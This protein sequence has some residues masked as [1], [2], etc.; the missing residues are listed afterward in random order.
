MQSGSPGGPLQG[1]RVLD[2]SRVLSGPFCTM[3]LADLGA[4]VIK[5]EEPGSGDQ[6]R[7]IPPYVNGE[8]HYYLAINR[9]KQSVVIDLKK[10]RARE[11][12]D[13]LVTKSDVLVENFRPGVMERLGLGYER[14]RALKPDLII[15]S[16]SG[17]GQAGPLRDKPSFD[18]VIQA[19]SGVMSVTGEPDGPPGKLGIP[20]GDLAGGLWGAIAILAALYDR[21]VTGQGH[22]I[23]LGLLDGMIG[24]L[25]YLAEIYLV[26]GESPGR[27]GARHHSVVPYGRFE[28]KDGYLVLAIHVGDFWR[29]FCRAVGKEDLIY[30]PRFRTTSDRRANREEL[31]AIVSDILRSKTTAEWLQILEAADVPNAPVLSI[32]EAL[33]QEH[34]KSRGLLEEVD[35]PVA[36]RVKVPGRVIR[37]VGEYDQASFRPAPILGQHTRAVLE[38]LLGYSTDEVDQLIRDGVVAVPDDRSGGTSAIGE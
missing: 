28:T 34:V 18:L 19:L 7:T 13:R 14:L 33:E 32:A 10:P 15:C 35:H 17:F 31:E 1:V 6:T 30:D 22:H 38:G 11:I 26:T 20:M 5:I 4:E 8:S 9:N 36:G 24:L 12:M 21:N 37:Y 2:L 29:K 23:D 25:G 27:V 3:I 16:I